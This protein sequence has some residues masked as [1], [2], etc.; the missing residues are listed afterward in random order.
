MYYKM[1]LL[2]YFTGCHHL[3]CSDT[4]EYTLVL[5]AWLFAFI[6]LSDNTRACLCC[7]AT[8]SM[9]RHGMRLWSKKL[10]KSPEET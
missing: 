4:S 5:H 6:I 10:P 2:W 3:G 8:L 9:A 1:S 7:E